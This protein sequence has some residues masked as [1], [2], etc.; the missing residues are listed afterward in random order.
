MRFTILS[1]EGSF[2][3]VHQLAL[4]LLEVGLPL[5][6][7]AVA[8]SRR[9]SFTAELWPDERSQVVS[10]SWLG[11]SVLERWARHDHSCAR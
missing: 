7:L 3:L 6:S 4:E 9:L 2:I 5:I 8:S 10:P 11:S 1:L